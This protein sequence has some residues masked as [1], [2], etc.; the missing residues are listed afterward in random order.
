MS[1]FIKPVLFAFLFALAIQ[2]TAAAQ[3]TFINGSAKVFE[4][5]TTNQVTDLLDHDT[6]YD[7]EATAELPINAAFVVGVKTVIMCYVY[8]ATTLQVVE[9]I[10]VT[11]D[12]SIYLVIEGDTTRIQTLNQ[13]PKVS[14][15]YPQFNSGDH[16]AYFEVGLSIT[17]ISGAKLMTNLTTLPPVL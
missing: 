11:V 7:L 8:D 16:V 17:L 9:V 14:T 10:P 13:L 2:S 6:H 4:E 5:G 3:I 1:K 12:N 15:L